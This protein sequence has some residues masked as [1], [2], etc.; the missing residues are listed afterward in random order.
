MKTRSILK[1]WR[2]FL[3]EGTSKKFTEDHIGNKV[4]VKD[5]CGSCHKNYKN[6]PKS[7]SLKGILKQNDLHNIND[8][9]IVLVDIKGKGEKQFPQ[10]CVSLLDE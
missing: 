8:M 3:L 6:V 4:I 9:N 7:G 10:C 5:C 2:K 1:E